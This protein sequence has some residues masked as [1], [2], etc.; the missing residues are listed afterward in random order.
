LGKVKIL[1]LIFNLNR[2]PYKTGGSFHTIAAYSYR[3]TNPYNVMSG[4]SQ[5][6]IYDLSNWDQSISVLPTGNSGIPS[7]IHYCDQTQLYLA[8]K[9]HRDLFSEKLIR[10]NYRYKAVISPAQSK[11]RMN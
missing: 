10:E 8:G 2:G 7:S 3:Y 11:K 6:H 1:N 5:R 9:Y 4:A